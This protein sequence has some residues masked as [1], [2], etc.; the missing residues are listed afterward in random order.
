MKILVE[1]LKARTNERGITNYV[2]DNNLTEEISSK[3]VNKAKTRAMTL[4]NERNPHK[5]RVL[6]YHNDD[7]DETRTACKIIP[8][9]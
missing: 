1:T 5:I 4:K 3:D 2:V 7:P 9:E 6:E 8:L